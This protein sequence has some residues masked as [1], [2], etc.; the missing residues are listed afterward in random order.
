[1]LSTEPTPRQVWDEFC[2][3]L[4][5]AGAILDDPATPT[6][7]LTLAEG[8]R[9]LSR[10][11]AV[12]LD[13]AF[14]H[15]DT[16]HP[17]VFLAR[18]PTKLTGGVSP[19]ARY[20]EA[21]IDGTRTYRLSGTRGSAPMLEIGVY[22][23]KLGLQEESRLVGQ[24][25][26]PDI[27]VDA[28]GRFELLLSPDE[29]R[30]P[31]LLLEPDASYVYI[32]NY[33]LDW[34]RDVP[35]EFAMVCEGVTTP[36]EPLSL[37]RVQDGL[38]A[39]ARYTEAMP[40]WFA[41]AMG[42]NRDR[43]TNTLL[44]IDP[45]QATTMPGGHQLACGYF[46]LEPGQSLTVRFDPAAA[47]YWS[48]GLCNSFMEPLDWRWRT[49]SIN[50]HTAVEDPDGTV[51]IAIGASPPPAGNWLDTGG[52]REGL[53]NFRW[54]RTDAPLPAFAVEVTAA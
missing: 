42:W 41:A 25:Y 22:A 13:V 49:T 33:S 9:Y 5:A 39:A 14:E 21:F 11:I 2:D 17:W 19:D 44:A 4:K 24:V 12:G 47:P 48:L 20:H 36:P 46:R 38:R 40:R 7:D 1:M 23:G 45:G 50:A 51:T 34:S 28:D 15:A 52:H 10:I 37:A 54:A 16:E 31:D 3:S 6:D 35:A 26:E 32:R 18:T 27:E 53:V 8:V 30:A 43:A 29:A